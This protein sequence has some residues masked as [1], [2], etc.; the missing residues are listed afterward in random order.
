MEVTEEPRERQISDNKIK[1]N[2]EVQ[3]NVIK[4]RIK[5]HTKELSNDLKHN[6]LIVGDSKVRHIE[7]LMTAKTNITAYWRSGSTLNNRC[8]KQYIDQHI[9]RFNKPIVILLFNTCYLTNVVDKKTK[10]IDLVANYD[11]VVT[12]TIESYRAFKQQRLN[13]KP[14]AQIFFIECPFYS[15]VEWNRLMKHPQPESFQTNQDK[16][17]N[18]IKELNSKIK[19]L[20]APHSPPQIAQDMFVKIKRKKNHTQTRRINYT[21]LKDGI[22]PGKD[23]SQLWL[24]RINNFVTALN[25]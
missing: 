10:Y 13:N 14:A 16:L 7:Q 25:K 9:S 17:E 5:K 24:V 11:E 22:H 1:K 6:A 23:L 19:E 21:L 12:I 18:M 8:L 2:E 15:I 4:S 20:N 3:A